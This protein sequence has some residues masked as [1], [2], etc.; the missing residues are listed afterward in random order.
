MTRGGYTA[1]AALIALAACGG[2][3][4]GTGGSAGLFVA[5]GDTPA[6]DPSFV[7]GTQATAEL[8]L[9][10]FGGDGTARDASGTVAFGSGAVSGTILAG[11]LNDARTRI[12]L[13]GGGWIDLTDPAATEYVRVADATPAG[14]T[15]FFGVLGIP[16][17]PSDLPASGGISYSGRT[18]L[19]AV[20]SLTTYSLA[21]T[22]S[23]AA[24]FGAGR[25]R[26]D[27]GDLG[28]TAQGIASASVAP[29][30]V[31]ATGRIVIAGSVISGARFSGGTASSSGLP[32]FLS[33]G[34]DASGTQGAFFGP[35]AD[36]VGGRISIVDA[37][38]DTQVIGTFV[39]E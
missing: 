26:I 6:G 22:A 17:L 11:R 34:A 13:D 18:Q 32:F 37:T 4:G 3:G 7:P 15:P 31:P 25:V 38:A 29:S 2:G 12:D 19:L 24:D 27:L 1:L 23:I 8:L 33:S 9:L 20:D 28:G 39:A 21:G 16:S 35:G 5:S 36:E 30:P 14:G 10:A